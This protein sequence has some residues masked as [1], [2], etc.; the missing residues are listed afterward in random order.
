MTALILTRLEERE[1]PDGWLVAEGT[2]PIGIVTPGGAIRTP[3][4]AEYAVRDRRLWP[5]DG[6]AV[7]GYDEDAPSVTDHA[8][9]VTWQLRPNWRAEAL[10]P[11]AEGNHT[12]DIGSALARDYTLEEAQGTMPARIKLFLASLALAEP[13]GA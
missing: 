7:A 13:T 8:G 1:A 3:S 6:P 2:V 5:A 4:G 9:G 12:L 11:A 10:K